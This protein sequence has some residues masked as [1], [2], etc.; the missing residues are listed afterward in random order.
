MNNMINNNNIYLHTHLK[1]GG[2]TNVT[3]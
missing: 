2:L 3:Q 1:G